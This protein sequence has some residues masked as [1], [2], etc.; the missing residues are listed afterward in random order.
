M[1][2]KKGQIIATL[3]IGVMIVFV[4]GI[5]LL[6]VGIGWFLTAN[7]F[8]LIGGALLIIGGLSILKGVTGKATMVL[9]TIGAI[10]LILPMLMKGLQSLTL[11]SIGIGG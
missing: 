5:L 10:L 6:F 1:K 2:N 11:A 3:S 4:I 7:L 8:T 9:L